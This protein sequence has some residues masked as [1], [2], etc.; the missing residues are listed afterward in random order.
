MDTKRVSGDMALNYTYLGSTPNSCL[1]FLELLHNLSRLKRSVCSQA[2]FATQPIAQHP[3]W[4]QANGWKQA[5]NHLRVVIQPS[6]I[7][8]VLE[9][10]LNL[11]PI[12]RLSAGLECLVVL[13]NRFPSSLPHSDNS[14]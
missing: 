1:K 7:L 14:P 6:V 13:M 10:W 4:N 5:Y 3:G 8:N 9:P 11:F 2:V 12:P